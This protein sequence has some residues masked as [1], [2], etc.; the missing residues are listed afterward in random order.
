VAA[1]LTYDF[2]SNR[3]EIIQDALTNV[4]AL[5]P[6]K[7]PTGNQTAHAARLLN[8]LV[9]SLDYE[10]LYLWRVVRRTFTTTSGDNS[11]DL[12]ADVLSVDEPVRL[13]HTG[14][15]QPLLLSPMTRDEWMTVNRSES[16]T[17]TR[18][19][20]EKTLTTPTLNLYP[21]PDNSTDTIE[22]AAAI[23]SRDFDTAANTPDFP[24]HWNL[25]LVNGLSMLLGPAYN[26]L[27]SASFYREEFERNKAALTQQETEHGRLSLVPWGY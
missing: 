7:T 17:P 8:R 16:G 12:A 20:F 19:F 23:K 4:G 6:N 26:Q 10:G 9:K 25:M 5:G 11:Q 3:D 1:G 27:Q 18:Y 24:S 15:T 21:T 22:Y 14:E 2:E 13:L